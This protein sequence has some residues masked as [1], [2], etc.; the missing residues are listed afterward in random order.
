MRDILESRKVSSVLLVAGPRSYQETGAAKV[1]EPLL[2]GRHVER[3]QRRDPYPTL[4]DIER[5]REVLRR[6]RPELI[7]AVGGGAVLD[8]AKAMR[9]PFRVVDRHGRTALVVDGPPPIVPLVAVPTTAG[10]G[11]ETTRFAVVYVDGRKHSL[12]HPTVLPDHAIIDPSLTDS[13]GPRETAIT[14]LDALAQA[15]E[16][17]WS[18]AATDRSQRYAVR[19]ARLA[20]ACLEEAALRPTPA[21]RAAMSLAAHLAGRAIDLTR[22]T[23]CHAASYPMTARFGIPHGHAVALTLPAMLAFNA[24]VGEGDVAD[25]R[26]V[27]AV[28]RRIATVLALLGVSE[29]EGGRRRLLELMRRLSLETSLAELGIRDL[30]VILAEGLSPERTGNNPRRLTRDDLREMLLRAS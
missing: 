13:L 9:V 10:T 2:E 7:I 14:G 23:A 1:L 20:L 25:P 19:A 29:A 6:S 26:G 21:A 3:F 24:A 18:V 15:I 16:S 27:T 8:L 11:A 12:D 5:G 28:Q 4:E 30:E 22:T 17:I